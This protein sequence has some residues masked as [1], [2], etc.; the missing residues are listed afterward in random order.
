MAR[1]RN[2]KVSFEICNHRG[3][4]LIIADLPEGVHVLHLSSPRHS[5]FE[6][7][8]YNMCNVEAIFDFGN[9]YL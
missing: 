5:V 2:T 7:K 4:D 1:G 9:V 6:W 8:K 3:L